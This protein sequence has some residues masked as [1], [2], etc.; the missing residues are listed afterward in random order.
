MT[1]R[2]HLQLGDEEFDALMAAT[3]SPGIGKQHWV[4]LMSRLPFDQINEN[5]QRSIP[6]IFSNLRNESEVPDRERM[7]GAFKYTWAKNTRMLFDVRPVLQELDRLDVNYRVIKG[8]AVLAHQ[9]QFGSRIMGD[10]DL[11]IAASDCAIVEKVFISN[12]FRRSSHSVCAG[13]SDADHFEALNFNAG[14]THV[15]LHVA[16]FKYP[17]ALL[18]LMLEQP[19]QLLSTP[20]GVLPVPDSHL[21]LL[22][23]A[24]HGQAAHGPTDLMQTALDFTTLSST[25]S[26]STL[27]TKARQTGTLSA[28]ATVDQALAAINIQGSGA[29]LNFED[30]LTSRTKYLAQR[31]RSL[32]L[33]SSSLLRRAQ[34][35]RDRRRSDLDLQVIEREFTGHRVW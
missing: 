30:R 11:L 10:I 19:A 17:N 28:L 4:A 34:A 8:A 1:N 23:S 18:E 9:G 2:S 29:H 26:T 33:D 14:A 31:S 6:A 21:L 25:I 16:E 32:L 3:Q 13:H 22:H 15:D 5:T 7:R 27:L 20:I 24:V 12:G 35:A